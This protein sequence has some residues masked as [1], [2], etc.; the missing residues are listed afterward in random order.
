MTVLIEES[1]VG[2]PDN[3]I[4]SPNY[5]VKIETE[6]DIDDDVAGFRP[7]SLV[8]EEGIGYMSPMLRLRLI[9]LTG[10][11]VDESKLPP[12]EVF[13]VHIGRDDESLEE[14]EFQLSKLS[15]EN[16]QPQSPSR[17]ALDLYFLIEGWEDFG[18]KRHNRSWKGDE[19]SDVV[20]EIAG[21]SGFDPDVEDT[22]EFENLGQE[23]DENIIYQLHWTNFQLLNWIAKRARSDEHGCCGFI[24]GIK[25]N[26]EFFFKTPNELYEEDEEI[27][28][29]YTPAFNDEDFDEDEP[30]YNIEVVNDYA[31]LLKHGASG[32]K[33][34]WFDYMEKEYEEDESEIEDTG[35]DKLS[36]HFYIA[37]E[38]LDQKGY[39]YGHR[40]TK[41]KDVAEARIVHLAHS[42]QKVRIMVK[43][44]QDLHIGDI[45]KIV[46][47]SVVDNDFNETLSGKYMISGLTH[48]ISFDEKNGRGFWTELTLQRA[49]P[50]GD[51]E[52]VV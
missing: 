16:I 37:E 34:K 23:N 49:G 51:V 12:D 52:G 41:A 20:E 28:Y 3:P 1:F 9:D 7:I 36:D 40:D 11:L 19:Y 22:E 26:K 4:H 6:T 43:G 18:Y 21:D 31:S 30:I 47:A 42:I 33:Y 32:F 15:M 10:V 50:S 14:F 13:T 48:K 39:Y 46:I 27:E 25:A 29:V 38:H 8:L 44:N 17:L 5:T 35:V 2:D 45:V 24:F